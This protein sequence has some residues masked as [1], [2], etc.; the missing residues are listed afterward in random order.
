MQAFFIAVM[1]KAVLGLIEND[2]FQAW[3][4]KQLDS[5]R[6]DV[7]KDIQNIVTAK[8]DGFEAKL[9]DMPAKIVGEGFDDVAHAAHWI[10]DGVDQIP[11]N[12]KNEIPQLDSDKI[13]QSVFDAF[14][15]LPVVGPMFNMLG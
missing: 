9:I 13:A 12:L 11:G 1:M 2:K 10:S 8:F 15:R 14:K 4:T 5:L 3:V 6:K 7:T